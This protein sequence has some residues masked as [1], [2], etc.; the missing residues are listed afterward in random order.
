MRSAPSDRLD[1]LVV[2]R[3]CF[4]S[5]PGLHLTVPVGSYLWGHTCGVIP[6]GSHLWG[7][8]CGV[9]PVGSYLWGHTCGVTH[10]GSH[11]WGHTCGVTPVVN[12]CALV[13]TLPGAWH[14]RVSARQDGLVSVCCD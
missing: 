2:G 9:T 14:Y 7:H 4:E 3:L 13:A 11:L 12:D 6:V 5:G 10:V 1:G 8:T